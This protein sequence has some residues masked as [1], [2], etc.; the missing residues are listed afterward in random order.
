MTMRQISQLSRALTAVG[1]LMLVTGLTFEMSWPKV[2]GIV[3]A[4]V[5]ILLS[6]TRLRCPHCKGQIQDMKA[7]FCAYCGKAIDYDA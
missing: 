4:A 6:W 5:G 2:I 3:I 1:L 7:E